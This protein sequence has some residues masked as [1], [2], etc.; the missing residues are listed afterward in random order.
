MAKRRLGVYTTPLMRKLLLAVLMALGA[1]PSFAAGYPQFKENYVNDFAGVLQDLDARALR[2]RLTALE[3]STGIEGTVVTVKSIDEYGTGAMSVE[4]FAT[5]LFNAWGVG[6]KRRN[7]GFMVLLS[8]KDRKCRI[9]LGDG[10]G[11]RLNEKSEEIVGSVMV[12]RFKAGDYSRGLHDGTLAFIDAVARKV[13]FWEYYKQELILGAVLAVLVLAGISCMRSGKT[14]WG[15]AFFAA[16]GVVLAF[17]IKALLSK[18]SGSSGSGGFG[19]GSSS[20]RGG[21]SG[22][23]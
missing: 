7:D 10:Y 15:W 6:N 18:R 12:P 22:S 8:L 20:G 14:G 21:A 1:A 3:K 4:Q 11:T 13:S 2:E 17:L 5:G 23:W 16:A 19:G 9:E